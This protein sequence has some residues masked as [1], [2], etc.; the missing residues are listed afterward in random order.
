MAVQTPAT[1][2]QKPHQPAGA[3][4]KAHSAGMQQDVAALYQ[5]ASHLSPQAALA[6]GAVA[7]DQCGRMLMSSVHEPSD[8]LHVPS[9][10]FMCD[11]DAYL[12]TP[13]HGF[14]PQY[15][16]CTGFFSSSVPPE[17]TCLDAGTAGNHGRP[18][19]TSGHAQRSSKRRCSILQGSPATTT[20]S[21]DEV[22][23]TCNCPALHCSSSSSSSSTTTRITN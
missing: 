8:V 14:Q 3:E 22:Q 9:Y 1:N 10:S 15:A 18:S 23:S 19:S 17:P 20:I 12:H 5:Q 7:G 2:M 21:D 4:N 6:V 11:V 13:P 16:A